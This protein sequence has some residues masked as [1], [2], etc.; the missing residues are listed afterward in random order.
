MRNRFDLSH[1]AHSVGDIGRLMTLS[2]IPVLPNDS[3]NIKMEGVVRLAKL[4]KNLLIDAQIDTFAF[5]VPHRH[6]Y[7]ATVWTKFLKD[8]PAG[9]ALK[10]VPNRTGTTTVH[11][12]GLYGSNMD[13]SSL[14]IPKHIPNGYTNIW[15]RYFRAPN[16]DED[17]LK[18]DWIPSD[19]DRDT[20]EYGVLC[21]RLKRPWN[22]GVNRN[23]TTNE[24]QVSTGLGK[25]AVKLVDIKI[26]KAKYEQKQDITY[27][28][29]R[30]ADIMHSKWGTYVN[31]DADE[32]PTL[33]MR[34]T[35]WMSGYDI[36]ATNTSG[37][38]D[39]I[40]K[41]I[42]INSMNM[43]TKHFSE[44]GTIWIQMLVRFP[45]IH[46]SEQCPLDYK[47]LTQTYDRVAGDPKIIAS[48]QPQ[49]INSKQWFDQNV[50][51]KSQAECEIPY[52]EWYRSHPNVVHR[53]YQQQEG[54]PFLKDSYANR[55]Q[56]MYHVDGEYD[57]V[58]A[59][60]TLRDWRASFALDISV[61]RNLTTRNEAINAG[62]K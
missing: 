7:G 24:L 52:A 36:D 31:T 61:K 22:T 29:K 39:S 37:L 4:N 35:E 58:F 10:K 50:D 21:G 54:Y 26:A 19:D 45:T 16:F 38:G 30:Y 20:R 17:I 53:A 6:V 59:E 40:G 14:K 51:M 25:T 43:P 28:G 8:G 41:A 60:R 32:R 11:Q 5:F 48:K 42:S 44:H 47:D 1:Q 23:M 49:L 56:Y 15:N 33:L 18:E 9:A 3:M 34:K 55:K 12:L 2:R 57:G 13:S 46:Q 62:Y 27:G